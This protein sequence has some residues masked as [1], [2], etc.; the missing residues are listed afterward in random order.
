[1]KTCL[2]LTTFFFSAFTQAATRVDCEMKRDE[3]KKSV[4]HFEFPEDKKP[5][6]DFEFQSL[7]A[8]GNS[9]L[10]ISLVHPSPEARYVGV[11]FHHEEKLVFILLEPLFSAKTEEITSQIEVVSSI[12]GPFYVTCRTNK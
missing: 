1:M 10:K 5:R 8:I 7:E 3:W 4:F 2:L 6:V 12:S 9:P 11:N